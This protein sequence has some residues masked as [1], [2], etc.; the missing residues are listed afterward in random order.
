MLPCSSVL[1]CL[2]S[3]MML[4]LSVS[5]PLFSLHGLTEFDQLIR[6]RTYLP[7]ALPL[8][9]SVHTNLPCCESGLVDLHQLQEDVFIAH[10]VGK[11]L[12]EPP[13]SVRINFNFRDDG[14]HSN[15]K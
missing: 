10:V 11:P 14:P 13:L 1:L 5:W 2:M 9:R 15:E 3:L 6:S 8:L 4:Y 7:S 12:I